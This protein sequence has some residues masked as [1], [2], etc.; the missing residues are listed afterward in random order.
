M[1]KKMTIKTV[2]SN[3]KSS[4]NGKNISDKVSPNSRNCNNA[5]AA[6]CIQPVAQ[7]SS[8]AL[9]AFVAPWY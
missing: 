8:P 5:R 2:Y 7:G 1:Y 3:G 9:Q 6:I 4:L